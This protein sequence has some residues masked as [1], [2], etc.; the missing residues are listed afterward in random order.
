MSEEQFMSDTLTERTRQTGQEAARG[1]DRD[2]PIADFG[3]R[4]R[5]RRREGGIRGSKWQAKYIN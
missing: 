5:S 1:R 2:T 4:D 3:S